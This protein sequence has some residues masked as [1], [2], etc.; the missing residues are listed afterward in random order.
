[1]LEHNEL[2]KTLTGIARVINRAVPNVTEISIDL[3]GER[4]DLVVSYREGTREVTVSRKDLLNQDITNEPTLWRNLF[5]G[6]IR[7]YKNNRLDY[8]YRDGYIK[9]NTS[10]EK[11]PLDMEMINALIRM[12][13]LP[14]KSDPPNKCTRLYYY[15][16]NDERIIKTYFSR[17]RAGIYEDSYKIT[18]T[19]ILLQE[20]DEAYSKY[21]LRGQLFYAIDSHLYLTKDDGSLEIEMDMR[22]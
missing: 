13:S 21:N 7:S 17:S 12:A 20:D 4:L 16:D 11:S 15:H 5:K 3:K 10:W 8:K 2:G 9:L 6:L 19:E 22:F 1:M 14:F 18:N